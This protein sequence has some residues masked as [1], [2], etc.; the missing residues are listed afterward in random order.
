MACVVYFSTSGY[1]SSSTFG[2]IFIV[3][4]LIQ[5]VGIQLSYLFGGAPVTWCLLMDIAVVLF[6]ADLE[7][8]V[9]NLLVFVPAL[10][11]RRKTRP[12]NTDP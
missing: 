4:Y 3:L 9:G 11:E 8:G 12:G 5:K 7:P 10:E 2:K 6:T 1:V